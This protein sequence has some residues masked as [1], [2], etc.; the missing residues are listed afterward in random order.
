M[1]PPGKWCA[2]ETALGAGIFPGIF[3]GVGES[4]W[5]RKE[6]VVERAGPDP[7]RSDRPAAPRCRLHAGALPG[8]GHARRRRR[9]AGG[10]FAGAQVLRLLSRR[11]SP[12]VAAGDRPERMPHSKGKGGAIRAVRGRAALSRVRVRRRPGLGD[13]GEGNVARGARLAARR[14]P[15]G[16]RAARNP[17]TLLPGDRR[18]REGSYRHRDVAAVAGPRSAREDREDGGG[19]LMTPEGLDARLKAELPALAAPEGLRERVR[20]ALRAEAQRPRPTP[21]PPLAVAASLIIAVSGTWSLASRTAEDKVLAQ[22][23]LASHL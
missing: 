23:V 22:E 10:V 2:E 19:T 13:R 8:A 18:H 14:I 12:G 16:D 3:P 4:G 21:W 9:G 1:E 20:L 17:G 11:R 6:S 5:E 15:R 7:L